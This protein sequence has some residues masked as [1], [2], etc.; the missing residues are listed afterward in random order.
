VLKLKD[1]SVVVE[2]LSIKKLIESV[3]QNEELTEELARELAAERQ[4]VDEMLYEVLRAHK[5]DREDVVV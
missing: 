1:L 4:S 2:L 3:G 5:I